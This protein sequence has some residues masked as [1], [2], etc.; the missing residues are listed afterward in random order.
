MTA[1]NRYPPDIP[2][3]ADLERHYEEPALSELFDNLDEGLFNLRFLGLK[4]NREAKS[5]EAKKLLDAMRAEIVERRLIK[6]KAVWRIFPVNSAGDDIN[7]YSAAGERLA[8]FSF[9]RQAAGERLCLSDFAAPESGGRRDYAALLAVTCGEGVTG[10]SAR[11][12]AA[13]N[14]VR[15]YMIEALAL[16]LAEAAAEVV[17]YRIRGAWGIAEADPVVPL[18]RSRYR[19]KRYSFGYPVCPDLAGQ[20]ALFE[21]LRPEADA[22]IRLTDGLMM[23]PEAS[24][25]AIVF[26]NPNAVYF[27]I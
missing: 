26:H 3:P 11:E 8:V 10:I 18:L 27:G 19:G 22:G 14:Y 4:K 7:F 1:G 13:G 25:S 17:H 2:A 20:K 15:S 23:E 5:A 12:R 16:A 9:P 21:L 6:P 24:V